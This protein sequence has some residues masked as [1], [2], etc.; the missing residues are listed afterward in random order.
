MSYWIE[1][2]ERDL[3]RARQGRALEAE[4]EA[5]EAS[6]LAQKEAREAAELAKA[7]AIKFPPMGPGFQI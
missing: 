3:A 5:R 2:A 7:V 1:K 4:A 6:E